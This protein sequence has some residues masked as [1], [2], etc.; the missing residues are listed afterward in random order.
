MHCASAN[1]SILEIILMNRPA[2]ISRNAA[3][4]EYI[5]K[6]Y[7]LFF[8]NIEEMNLILEDNTIQPFVKIGNN[9]VIWSGNHIGHHSIIGD[10]NF[11][12]SQVTIAGRVEIKNNCFI[13]INSSIRDHIII[14]NYTLIG[15]G[16][17]IA[18]NTEIYG[19]YTIPSSKKIDTKSVELKI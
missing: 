7:P 4:E 14:E 2:F 9:N 3:T 8:N 12:T 13:G 1:N 5:G 6:D 19:V 16:T 18:K 11:I 17:W 10:N 15:A